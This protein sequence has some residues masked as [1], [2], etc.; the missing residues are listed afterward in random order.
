[1]LPCELLEEFIII[2]RSRLDASA[3]YVVSRGDMGTYELPGGT[4]WLCR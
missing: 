4:G 1:M 3:S 2:D